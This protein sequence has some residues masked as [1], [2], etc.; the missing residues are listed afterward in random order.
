MRDFGF[1]SEVPFRCPL[2]FVPHFFI[3]LGLGNSHVAHEESKKMVA[4]C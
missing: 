3:P 1:H 4:Y 2:P